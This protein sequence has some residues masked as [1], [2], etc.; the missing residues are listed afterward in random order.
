MTEKQDKLARLLDSKLPARRSARYPEPVAVSDTPTS[1]DIER[2][3]LAMATAIVTDHESLIAV[4]KS[5]GFTYVRYLGVANEKAFRS[6]LDRHIAAHEV[7]HMAAARRELLETAKSGNPFA[8][9]VA[10]DTAPTDDLTDDES[11]YVAQMRTA[12]RRTLRRDILRRAQ[13]LIAELEKLDR[14]QYVLM[15]VHADGQPSNDPDT[16]DG[17]PVQPSPSV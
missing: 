6:S 14:K 12:D 7:A 5:V 3:A 2:L 9:K 8:Y 10:N 11:A 13:E 17:E 16:P 1:D 15:P 4:L